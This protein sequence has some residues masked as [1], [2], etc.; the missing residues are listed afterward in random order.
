MKAAI[1]ARKST[2]QNVSEDAKSVTRQISRGKKFIE[3]KGWNH[4]GDYVDDA[5]S[6]G[7]LDRE[8]LNNLFRDATAGRF[9][10]VVF[11]DLDRFSRADAI[12]T[13]VKLRDLTK[14]VDVWEY[15][16]GQQLTVG[17]L[18]SIM[19]HFVAF[20]NQQQRKSASKDTRE[21]MQTAASEGLVTGNK[22]YGFDNIGPRGKR[23]RVPNEKQ[24]V[25]VR[26]IF[27]R[28]SQREG[29][30]AIAHILN[31]RGIPSPNQRQSG[32]SPSTVRCILKNRIYRGEVIY[33]R[34]RRCDEQDLPEHL[35]GLRKEPRVCVDESNWIIT[36]MDPLVDPK[37]FDL[38]AARFE[39]RK[40]KS[41]QRRA[42]RNVRH[43]LSGLLTCPCGASLEAV[44]SGQRKQ[45]YYVCSRRRRK[46]AAMCSN[47]IRL[48]VEKTDAI[49]LD[50][51][52]NSVLSPKFGSRILNEALSDGEPATQLEVERE[53][54][55]SEIGNLTKAV[56]IGGGDIPELVAALRERTKAL[57]AVEAK[58][59]ARTERPDRKQLREAVEQ[60]CSE[61]RE[62][63]RSNVEA[64]RA[65]LK[66]LVGPLEVHTPP[67]KELADKY[68]S[69]S[70]DVKPE[71]VALEVSTSVG[72][73]GGDRTRTRFP[74]G[75]F[76]SPA[77]AI[78]PPRQ[79]CSQ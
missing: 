76:K 14:L 62:V 54:L 16:N 25:I 64:G 23:Q 8:G 40:Q 44:K 36:N 33:G 29:L 10:A 11:Y 34:S 12:D 20:S 19:I 65:L 77:S 2:A 69:W 3:S 48:E 22:I 28:Y 78:P 5:T 59:A 53:R 38:C 58:L 57:T 4:A 27:D 73:G 24:A 52:E 72:T 74:P 26:E 7:S 9:D 18:Q 49:I 41:G 1:Y 51:L 75:D 56:A 32:W 21:K 61:W 43:L 39:S 17:D 6:G 46:G 37:T 70:A 30:K 67:P 71:G 63:L 35:Q 55:V 66:S 79:E 60:R 13:L 45:S 50:E 42:A 31:D 68:A 47:T 15:G